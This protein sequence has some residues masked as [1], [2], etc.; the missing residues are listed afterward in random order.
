[1][2]DFFFVSC[3][4]SGAKFID[5]L[6]IF[7][8]HSPHASR[9]INKLA[10][11]I[12]TGC[13]LPFAQHYAGGSCPMKRDDFSRCRKTAVCANTTLRQSSNDFQPVAAATHAVS[14]L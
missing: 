8:Y 13:G 4:L 5:L 2:V 12:P 10:R 11:K 3:L 1:V 7:F 9:K 6:V 14:T